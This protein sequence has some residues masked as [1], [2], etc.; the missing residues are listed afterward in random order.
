MTEAFR[1]CNVSIHTRLSG[2]GR[3]SASPTNSH[4]GFP[5]RWRSTCVPEGRSSFFDDPYPGPTTGTVLA[6]DPP[7]RLSFT[8]FNDE[9]HFE[10]KPIDDNSCKLTLINVLE[11]RDTA[12]RNAA[13]WSVCLAELGK[14]I[15]VPAQMDRTAIRPNRGAR[16]TTTMSAT[17]CH[18]VQTFLATPN[19]PGPRWTAES[20]APAWTNRS[21]PLSSTTRPS[22]THAEPRHPSQHQSHRSQPEGV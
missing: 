17:V 20:A 8:W 1:L 3:Q 4:G 6:V 9:L 12:S 11:A 15:S 14:H 2:C 19:A 10:L 21:W 5:P 13:G 22:I 7:R 18:R 16:T